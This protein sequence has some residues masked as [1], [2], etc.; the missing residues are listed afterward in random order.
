MLKN[1]KN[2]D[3]E[4]YISKITLHKYTPPKLKFITNRTT[5]Q[6]ILKEAMQRTSLMA[7]WIRICLLMQGTRVRSLLQEYHTCCRATKPMLQLFEPACSRAHE[8]HYRACEP[9]WLN[10]ARIEPVLRDKRGHRAK[11][12]HCGEEQ[13]LLTQSND[14]SAAKNKSVQINLKKEVVQA[15]EKEQGLENWSYT[16]KGRTRKNKER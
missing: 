12:A 11:P 14:P 16:N 7:Q 4:F 8:P 3:E 9:Q 6:E 15:E 2:I 1:K 13:P 5:L 10:S